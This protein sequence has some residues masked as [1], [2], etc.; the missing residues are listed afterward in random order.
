VSYGAAIGIMDRVGL[1]YTR[2]LLDTHGVAVAFGLRRGF[3]FDQ[4]VFGAKLRLF[5]DTVYDQTVS[6]RRSPYRLPRAEP[7]P[8]RAGADG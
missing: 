5:G 6:C 2:Q 4:D 1:S 7:L 8:R 3:T